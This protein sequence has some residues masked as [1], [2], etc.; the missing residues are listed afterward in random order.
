VKKKKLILSSS[1]HQACPVPNASISFHPLGEL[2]EK[3]LIS[4]P[5]AAAT[6]I[7]NYETSKLQRLEDMMMMMMMMM[8]SNQLLHIEVLFTDSATTLT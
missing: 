1:M 2:V 5:P 6:L 4:A 3:Q 7:S 8:S